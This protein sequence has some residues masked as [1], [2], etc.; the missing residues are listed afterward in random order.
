[1]THFFKAGPGRSLLF[2][3]A[4]VLASVFTTG[5][6][7]AA[8]EHSRRT[9]DVS[10]PDNGDWVYS[11][12]DITG[13]PSGSTVTSVE[14]S[15]RCAHT[16]S[17]DLEIDLEVGTYSNTDRLWDREGGAQ[18]NPS[19]T[20]STSAFNG[21]PVN[22]GWYLYAR[23]VEP[24]DAGFIDE[25]SIR[26]YYDLQSAVPAISAVNEGEAVLASNDEQWI[27]VEGSNFQ[28]GLDVWVKWPGGDPHRLTFPQ[29]DDDEVPNSFRMYIR[30][31]MVEERW[32]VKAENPDDGESDWMSFDVVLPDDDAGDGSDAR[33]ANDYPYRH[34]VSPV[35]DVPDQ[36]GFYKG[37]CTS[38]VAWRLNDFAGVDDENYVF[39]NR[40]H[41]HIG[42]GVP[43]DQWG[44]RFSDAT[45]WAERASA[46]NA[47]DLGFRVTSTP[48][49]GSIAHWGE[50]EG[51]GALGHVA[52]VEAVYEDGSVDVTDY[53]R[54]GERSFSSRNM[55][56]NKVPRFVDIEAVVGSFDQPAPAQHDNFSGASDLGS[57]WWHHPKLGFLVDA[58]RWVYLWSIQKWIYPIPGMAWEDGIYVWHNGTRSWTFT[59]EA[60]YPAVYDFEENVWHNVGFDF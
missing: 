45:Y 10:I 1:M 11:R 29:V 37:E 8:S 30:T 57:G 38:Y 28:S 43:K 36:W 54:Y 16:F 24:R 7:E 50:G 49:T 41:A 35:E 44:Y 46:F 15:F 34:Q 56:L 6:A 52:F 18:D 17:A 27:E 22:N 20:V 40:M 55:P 60:W 48:Q 12:I 5:F 47:E 58:D 32:Q 4:L 25:W 2:N 39:F 19:R 51:L 26:I 53:N 3:S 42:G 23:D 13:A 33:Y 59:R 31:T 9:N 21:L 14:V